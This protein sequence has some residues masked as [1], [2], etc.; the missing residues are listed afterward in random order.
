M[1]SSLA[2]SADSS[3]KAAAKEFIAALTGAKGQ[4]DWY[5]RTKD[6]PANIAAWDTGALAD[7]ATM[8]VF[9]KQM[10]SAKALPAQPKGTEITAQVDDAIGAVSQ[11][12]S[13]AK[14][15]LDKAQ[16]EIENLVG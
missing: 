16:S 11:G 9:R 14:E 2:I 12:K 8:N 6:L 1:G 10:E 3:H 4:A 15:A 13:T 7:D 5:G